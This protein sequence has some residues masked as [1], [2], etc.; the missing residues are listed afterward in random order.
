VSEGCQKVNYDH[1]S[2]ETRNQESLCW[3]GPEAIYLTGRINDEYGR[4]LKKTSWPNRGLSRNPRAGTEKTT[5]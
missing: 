2:R 4:I 3:R 1:E 5:K